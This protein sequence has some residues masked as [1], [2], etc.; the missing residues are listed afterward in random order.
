MNDHLIIATAASGTVRIYTAQTTVMVETARRLH[1]TWP[2][3]TAALGRALTGTAMMRVM[4]GDLLRLTVQFNGNGPLGRILAVSNRRGAV[5]GAL[6]NPWVDLELNAA[7]KFDVAGA[8]GGGSLVV[9]KDLGL[10]EPYLGVVPIQSGEIA[11]DFAYYF[12]KSEQTPSAV[13]LG[14]LVNPDGTV[15]AAGGL[16]IQLMPGATEAEIDWLEAKLAGFSNITGLLEAGMT[17]LQMA[18]EFGVPE[19]TAGTHAKEGGVKVLETVELAYECDCTFEHFRQAII[20]L[21]P[22]EIQEFFDHQNEIEV[23]CHFC[24][25]LYHYRPEELKEGLKD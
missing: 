8:L 16:I 2:A 20:S 6:D 14:V 15:Q 21:G 13:A 10:K 3:A 23:R 1:D 25:K 5:K 22:A 12:T 9:I 18:H 11:Q 19:E 17:P 24:N 4:D 7:G